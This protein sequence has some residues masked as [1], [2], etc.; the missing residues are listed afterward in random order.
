[1][2]INRP[3][4]ASSKATSERGRKGANDPVGQFNRFGPLD[5]GGGDDD[6]LSFG[7]LFRLYVVHSGHLRT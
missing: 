5:D 1:M 2:K 7:A 4:P 6:G 3:G